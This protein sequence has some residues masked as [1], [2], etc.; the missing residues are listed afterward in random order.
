MQ[1]AWKKCEQY[2]EEH[3][4]DVY[5]VFARRVCN[6]GERKAMDVLTETGEDGKPAMLGFHNFQHDGWQL[7]ET[8]SGSIFIYGI[9]SGWVTSGSESFL[10][11]TPKK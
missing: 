4:K 10:F 7:G 3:N 1:M 6:L 5:A 2:A 9:T 11:P 8:K